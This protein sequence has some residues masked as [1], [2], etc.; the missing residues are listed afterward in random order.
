MFSLGGLVTAFWAGMNSNLSMCQIGIQ[1]KLLVMNLSA[2]AV[3][4]QNQF[5]E[6]LFWVE[7]LKSITIMQIDARDY[8]MNIIYYY[9]HF[10]RHKY[11]MS[12]TFTLKQDQTREING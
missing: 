6:K 7:K 3:K 8:V 10:V 2:A 12:C 5:I 1:D 11:I 4:K 9:I